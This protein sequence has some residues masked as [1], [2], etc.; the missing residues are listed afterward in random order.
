MKPTQASTVVVGSFPMRGPERYAKTIV[1]VDAVI[2]RVN[3][4]LPDGEV[5]RKSR[6]ARQALALGWFWIQDTNLGT[7]TKTRVVLEDFAKEIGALGVRE[8]TLV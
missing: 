2:K 5:L 3:R 4:R 7:A 8:T 1:S 6:S